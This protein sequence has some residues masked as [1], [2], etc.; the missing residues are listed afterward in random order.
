LEAE[1]RARRA[2]AM[3][4]RWLGPDA[5]R[6]LAS[7]PSVET[8]DAHHVRAL[9]IDLES[10]PHLAIFAPMEAAARAELELAKAAAKPDWS[11]ELS[12]GQRGSAYSNMVSLMVR[13]DLP[14]FTSRRQDPVTQSKLR[15]VEQVR[16]QAEDAKRAH[17]ADIRAGFVDWDIAKSRLERQRS[18]GVPLAEE[19]SRSTL[20]AYEGGRAELGAVLEARRNVVE[21]RLARIAAEAELARAWSQLA[22][23]VP[24]TPAAFG[25]QR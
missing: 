10:H 3:L 1:R 18:D 17:L 11:V 23:L 5:E 25:R 9:E 13:M 16:A 15:K 22:F 20:A 4:G 24:S 6:P 12:Y 7:A 14:L 21:A 8:I 19:R 2:V